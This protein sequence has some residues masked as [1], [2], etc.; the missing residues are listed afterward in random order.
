MS[1]I[2][3]PEQDALGLPKRPL[4]HCLPVAA[5]LAAGLGVSLVKGLGLAPVEGV[6]GSLLFFTAWFTHQL[7]DSIRR[8]LWLCPWVSLRPTP[9][10]LYLTV[11]A[12][13]PLVLQPLLPFLQSPHRVQPTG[14]AF[15]S[16]FWISLPE[17]D[18]LD[19]CLS[20]TT[21]SCV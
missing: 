10:W 1:S 9:Y 14:P 12:L 11:I 19:H 13:I 6:R 16:Y 21:T 2:C 15:I 17:E 8:G 3:Y 20:S 4:G 7:R 18:T 5:A